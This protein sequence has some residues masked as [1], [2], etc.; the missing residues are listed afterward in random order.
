MRVTEK[1]RAWATEA[2]RRLAIATALAAAFGAAAAFP[3]LAQNP[4]LIA[5]WNPSGTATLSASTSSSN[6]A[7]A[8]NGPTA[9]IC[10][11]GSVTAFINF[12]NAS[13]TAATS[14]AP[15]L[16]GG[17]Q[18]FNVGGSGYI[19]AI[20]GTGSATLYATTGTGVPIVSGG[21]GN[22]G[23]GAPSGPAGGD[24]GGNYPNPEVSN[25]ANDG[26]DATAQGTILNN[27]NLATT[28]VASGNI[29][30]TTTIAGGTYT[31]WLTGTI[32]SGTTTLY[33]P[34][35]ASV[36]ANVPVTIYDSAGNVSGSD[37]IAITPQAGDTLTGGSTALDV[38]APHFSIIG[39]SNGVSAWNL[40]VQSSLVTLAAG[41]VWNGGSAC[42]G[43]TSTPTL[44]ASGT[45]GSITMGNATSSGGTVTLEPVTGSLG[46]VTA[47]LPANTGTIA[48]TNLAQT[49]SAT[50]T[51]STIGGYFANVGTYASTT[52]TLT[53]TGSAGCSALTN[54]QGDCGTF[55]KHTANTQ[56]VVT[57]PE[58]LPVG[59][60]VA[61]EDAGTY[62]ARGVILNGTAVSAATLNSAH[63]YLGTAAQYSVIGITIDA[64]SGGSAAVAVLT[65]DGD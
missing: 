21:G 48:E 55:I 19:A 52:C 3:A 9:L 56:L 5:A 18:A 32:P 39:V 34:H 1:I 2:A 25:V 59:C 60:Q 10:N 8:S 53:A 22:G 17:C 37:I 42:I 43:A 28:P 41:Q 15:I 11:S 35:A 20:T 26:S 44:G 6:T 14:G 33:L 31:Y 27:L 46:T 40:Y 50:Q 13:V 62:G 16:A 64:N 63:S 47:S 7:F 57:I 36:I 29:T 30:T 58:T 4:V 38:C 65:G 23:G 54:G 24:L 51:F 45:L 12:G 61:F 49:F